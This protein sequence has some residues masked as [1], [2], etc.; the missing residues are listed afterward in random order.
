M[1]DSPDGRN[2]GFWQHETGNA[3]TIKVTMAGEKKARGFPTL[4]LSL[5]LALGVGVCAIN[6]ETA[7]NRPQVKAV[8]YAPRDLH[9]FSTWQKL[10]PIWWIGNA[11]DP[12][13]PDTYRPGKR[14]RKFSWSIRNPFHNFTFYVIGISDKVFLRTGRYADRVANPQGGW[15]WA[16]C[17]Y[18]WLW[19]PFV[20][21]HRGR[22][23]FYFG[24]R[25]GGNFGLKLNFSQKHK[26]AK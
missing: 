3:L 22:F 20:D 8:V 26:K 18:Q 9:R 23:E 21:Y 4:S 1:F 19:L 5:M 11:D 12:A 7:T 17:R 2:S 10:N 24:W 25:N 14:L 15:N 6:A 13:P 16:V